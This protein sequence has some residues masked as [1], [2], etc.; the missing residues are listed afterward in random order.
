MS[1]T[2][3]QP[4]RFKSQKNNNTNDAEMQVI[5]FTKQE[6][7]TRALKTLML[8]WA[9]A[10]VCVLIPIA[11]FFL[12]PGFLIGGAIAAKRR[13]N[14]EKEGIDAS[15][16]CP[17]CKNNIRIP[18]DKNAELPQWHDCPECGDALELQAVEN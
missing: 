13:W 3:I 8:F 7:K 5:A 1:E 15:G 4:I 14:K 17:A 2:M 18:L 11:H 9:I 12:V 6:Q 16:V 10:L